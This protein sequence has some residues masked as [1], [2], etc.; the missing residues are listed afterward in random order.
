[1][2]K[3]ILAHKLSLTK[4]I[5]PSRRTWAEGFSLW[6]DRVTSDINVEVTLRSSY[7]VT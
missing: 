6:G 5:R 1:M 7:N 4:E 3:V 2:N